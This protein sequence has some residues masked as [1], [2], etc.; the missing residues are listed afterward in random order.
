MEVA[1]KARDKTVAASKVVA[2]KTKEAALATK[3]KALEL[4]TTKEEL[5]RYDRNHDGKL[6]EAERARMKTA[7]KKP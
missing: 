4:T 7:E 6:D 1:A 2:E 5:A 3:E